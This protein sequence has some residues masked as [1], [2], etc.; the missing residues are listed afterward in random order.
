MSLTTSFASIR[1]T[2]QRPPGSI[3]AALDIGSTKIVCFIAQ[4]EDDGQ[5]R[6]IGIGHTAAAGVRAGAVTE[7][8]TAART[9]SSTLQHA[10]QMSG[11]TL[12]A[13]IVNLSGAHAQSHVADVEVS[14]ITGRVQETDIYRAIQST[15][16]LDFGPD[17]QLVHAMPVCYTLDQQQRNILDPIDMHGQ[18]LGV[19]MHLVTG[20]TAALHNLSSCIARSHLDIDG[21]CIAPYAS[22]LA[23]LTDDEM[24]LGVTVIDFGGGTTSMAVFQDGHVVYTD[25]LPVG[26]QHITS[27]IARGLNTSLHHAERLKVLYGG[28]LAAS[29]DD[30]EMLDV[31]LLGEEEDGFSA[32]QVP[33]SLLVGIIRPRVEETMELV[34]ARLEAI[35][36]HRGGGRRV[37]ITGGASQ[38][39]G[40]RDLAQAML[41][42]QIRLGKPTR[43][44]GLAESTIG[45]GFATAAG[46]LRYGLDYRIDPVHLDQETETRQSMIRRLQV[47]LRNNL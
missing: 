41:D 13:V 17:Q 27:D 40:L 31:P 5:L 46:L 34:R 29:G 36:L 39:T 20:S 1:R 24:A 2:R 47:W 37:V 26:G 43:L 12:D 15:Q 30:R 4:V 42:K 28:V 23:C 33:K 7:M 8:E 18:I 16:S 14:V 9:I 6:I 3:V 44:H 32:N 45:P 35:G 10:E 22:G 38:L 19:Q 25:S 21:F 11:E